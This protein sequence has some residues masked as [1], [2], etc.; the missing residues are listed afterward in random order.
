MYRWTRVA[1]E[2]V[3]PT[4]LDGYEES[5]KAHLS[6]VLKP[7]GQL[8]G[9]FRVQRLQDVRLVLD[10][11]PNDVDLIKQP[12]SIKIMTGQCALEAS[13]HRGNHQRAQV[14]ESALVETRGNQLTEQAVDFCP[15][16]LA[17]SFSLSR[18]HL[19]R[20]IGIRF[21]KIVALMHREAFPNL[22]C[23]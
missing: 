3:A 18:T 13:K 22:P 10:W 19:R 2:H 1:G 12:K 17:S 5:K 6:P 21:L 9:P 11:K 20:D 14:V 16:L 4:R 15:A 7:R 23:E 8:G